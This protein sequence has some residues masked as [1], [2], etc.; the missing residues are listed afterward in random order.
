M[1]RQV[2]SYP[3]SGRTWIRYA[4]HELGVGGDVGFHHDTFEYNDA[5]RPQPSY[6]FNARQERAAAS[7][8]IVYVERDPRDV[9]VSIYHQVTGRFRDFFEYDGT[10]SEFIRDDYFG[11]HNLK[12]FTDQWNELCAMGLARKVTYEQCHEDFAGV[13]RG[14]LDHLALEATDDAIAR[15]VEASSFDNMKSV[16][17]SGTFGGAWL[18]PREGASKV[19]RGKVGGFVDYLAAADIRYLDAMFELDEFAHA[20]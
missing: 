3:K 6:D 5:A 10:I 11:A 20:A 9:M 19:R 4:L 18:R 8:A 1:S 2:V 7:S 13:L 17:Q 12:V 14:V 16:E 15:A